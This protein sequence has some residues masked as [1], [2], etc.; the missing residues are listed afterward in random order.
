[1]KA[2][3]RGVLTICFSVFVYILMG[4]T[5]DAQAQYAEWYNNAQE[6][7][8]TLRKADFGVKI[9]DRDGLPFEGEVAVRM[10]KHEFPFGIAFDLYEGSGTMGNTYSTSEAIQADADAEIYQTERWNDYLA[11]AI[12]VESG[13]DYEITLK[14]AEIYFSAGGSRIFDARV[15]RELFLDDIDVFTV[16]GGRNIALD[17]SVV[18]TA[19]VDYISIELTASLD[20]VALKGI[21]VS[22]DGGANIVRIN[23]GGQALTTVDGNEYVSE[24]GFFDPEGFSVATREQWMKAALS[25]IHI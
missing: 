22:E 19:T 8:D 2:S 11:Y 5:P 18:V 25:L 14:F 16:A 7:I 24:V 20:N 1:M 6:R 17:T 4:L 3:N 23:C 15:E 21:E 12:P 13:K 9:Y 10:K